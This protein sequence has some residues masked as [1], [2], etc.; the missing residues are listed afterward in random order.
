MADLLHAFGTQHPGLVTLHNF[1]AFLQEFER[2][3]GGVVDLA[4][5]DILR[6]RELGVRRY[7]AFRRL[8]H[9]P[10]ARDF[11]QIAP[12]AATAATMRE[13][14]EG[15]IERVDLIIGMYGEPLPAR[16][17]FSDTAFRIFLLMAPRRLASDR[18]FTTDYT[19]RVYTR[20]GLEWID[21]TTMD[22]A[23]AFQPWAGVPR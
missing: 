16:F 2:P 13:L 5:T 1:P 6:T 15:D 21:D 19:P 7:N 3:R 20:A 9:L 23:N 18:F 12:D 4:A 11:R 14:Y 8:L 22:V 17:A 10:P